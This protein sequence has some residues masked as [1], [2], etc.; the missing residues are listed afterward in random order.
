MLDAASLI[1][2]QCSTTSGVTNSLHFHVSALTFFLTRRPSTF[3]LIIPNL[4][5]TVSTDTRVSQHPRD[6]PSVSCDLAP[7]VRRLVAFQ[8]PGCIIDPANPCLISQSRRRLFA[9]ISFVLFS[10]G[11]LLEHKLWVCCEAMP[12]CRST[13]RS[14]TGKNAFIRTSRT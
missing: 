6:S 7:H 12:A 1:A 10:L 9:R 8:K 5:P 13:Y 4:W 3:F 11:G 2:V 14:G